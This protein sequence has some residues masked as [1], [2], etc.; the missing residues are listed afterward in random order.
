M[1]TTAP[2]A[3]PGTNPFD[4]HALVDALSS[5]EESAASGSASAVVGAISAAVAAKAARFADDAGLLAQAEAL[6]ARLTALAL[7]DAE[8]FAAATRA[9]EVPRD[10]ASE[11]R[12]FRL[13]Q[14]L[15]RAAAVPLAIAEASA[16]VTFLA[17]ELAR[18]GDPNLRPDAVAASILAAAAAQAAA[19][20]V[21]INLAAGTEVHLVE[22]AL[23]AA[24]A[25][26]DAVRELSV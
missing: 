8:A 4:L 10:G 19:H 14:A 24:S 23:R 20:L 25:A 26:S 3:P 15:V 12:D 6:S 11:R 7:E 9:L 13:G 17:V 16:D 21:Q 18:S 2:G 22:Q 1:S 5:R